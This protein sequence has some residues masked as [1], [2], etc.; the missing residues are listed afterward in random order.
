MQRCSVGHSARDLNAEAARD[1]FDGVR[2]VRS[3]AEQCRVAIA[4]SVRE[5]KQ[6][7]AEFGRGHRSEI[8][9]FKKGRGHRRT[10]Y[11]DGS[12]AKKQRGPG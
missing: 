4:A 10:P 11:H 12:E 2:R 8:T 9:G 3:S 5:I 6:R 1:F 7:T